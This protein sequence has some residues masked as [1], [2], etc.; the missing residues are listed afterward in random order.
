MLIP[1]WSS[2]RKKSWAEGSKVR[3]WGKTGALEVGGIYFCLCLSCK[4]SSA[5]SVITRGDKRIPL[6][7]P[8]PTRTRELN[9]NASPS[10]AP[11]APAAQARKHP[12]HACT[13]S[14]TCGS[15][16]LNFKALLER[17]ST[18]M[19]ARTHTHRS[20]S[21]PR[22]GMRKTLTGAVPAGRRLAVAEG[23]WEGAQLLHR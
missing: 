19:H 2:R 17:A 16:P 4:W 22:L 21:V 11:A 18:H 7:S 23:G 1:I 15:V 6:A 5:F 3:V 8:G 14:E 10:G 13:I 12:A 9:E 20:E